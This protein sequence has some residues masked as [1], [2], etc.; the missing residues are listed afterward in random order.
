MDKDTEKELVLPYKLME[1]GWGDRRFTISCVGIDTE[2]GSKAAKSCKFEVSYKS[3]S[4]DCRMPLSVQAWE[5]WAFNYDLDTAYDI[6]SCRNAKAVLSCGNGELT[7]VF[8]ENCRCSVSGKFDNGGHDGVFF[9]LAA[10]TAEIGD[11]IYS[12]EVF[13]DGLEKIQGSR[14]FF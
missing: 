5:L 11:S 2:A 8:D 3:G 9:T 4:I 7:I 14:D 10:D 6:N 13:F 1:I 12:M